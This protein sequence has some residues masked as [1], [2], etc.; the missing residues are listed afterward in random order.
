MLKATCCTLGLLLALTGAG[1]SI[2]FA[3]EEPVLPSE[4]N[5]YP[6]PEDLQ[7]PMEE[8]DTTPQ[9]ENYFFLPD[10]QEVT[11]PTEDDLIIQADLEQLK[12]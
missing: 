7:F 10:E 2:T 12:E 4:E 8:E 11:H 5:T 3:E 1:S 6:M 9:D